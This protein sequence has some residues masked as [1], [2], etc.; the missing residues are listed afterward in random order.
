MGD[1]AHTNGSDWC[2]D[3]LLDEHSRKPGAGEEIVAVSC[4]CA[5]LWCSWGCI[6]F[7]QP[8][9]PDTTRVSSTCHLH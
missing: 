4:T 9:F 1:W 8:E 5:V 3:T 7:H 6:L 2:S